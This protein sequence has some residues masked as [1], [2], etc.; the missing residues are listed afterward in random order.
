M[1]RKK[2]LIISALLASMV[3]MNLHVY[4]ED[5]NDI[6]FY[7]KISTELGYCFVVEGVSASK[8]AGKNINLIVL[9]P[10]ASFEDSKNDKS[11]LMLQYQNDT[12]TDET[13]NFKFEFPIYTDGYNDSGIYTA[14]IGGDDYSKNVLIGSFYFASEDDKK[15]RIDKICNADSTGMYSAVTEAAEVLWRD[16]DM[17]KAVD[18][19]EFAKLLYSNI[20]SGEI[21]IDVQDIIDAETKLNQLLLL[22]AYNDGLKEFVVDSNNNFINTELID[23]TT[24][25]ENGADIYKNVYSE[26]L[27]DSGKAKLVNNLLGKEVNTIK[28]LKTLFVQNV[29]ALAV[30]NSKDSGYGHVAKILTK[31]NADVTKIDINGY[32]NLSNNNKNSAASKLVDL[33][34]STSAELED[35]LGDIVDDINSPSKPGGN[36]SSGGG[37]GSGGSKGQSTLP[38]IVPNQNVVNNGST[39][40]N[41]VFSDIGNTEWAKEAILFLNEKGIVSGVGENK[42]NPNSAITR[43]QIAKILAL[44]FEISADNSE[45]VFAD[46]TEGQWYYEYISALYENGIVNGISDSEF[47]VGRSVTRQDFAVM[48]YRIIGNSEEISANLEF[49]DVEEI[50]DYALNAVSYLSSKGIINGFEDGSFG[51]KKVLTRAQAAKI[52]YE[53]VKAGE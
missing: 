31:E 18:K 13:G 11:K 21:V 40:S 20:S 30:N 32:L 2:H 34:I 53:I 9:N 12:V 6:K 26:I 39:I 16:S 37:S 38:S 27:N 36:T 28:D 48:V 23:Y 3:G 49:T 25:D 5:S 10:G 52:I 45:N 41:E 8:E 50:S 29:V 46:V 7:S 43:E 14:Y 35:K 4:A 42:F 51:A 22:S 17:Y 33:S 19:T 44:A 47:G 24:I 1:N 15:V